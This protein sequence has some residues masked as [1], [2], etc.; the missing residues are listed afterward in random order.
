PVTIRFTPSS[1]TTFTGTL[2]VVSNDPDTPTVPVAM[3]G[4]GLVAPIAGVSPDS[5]YVAVTEGGAADRTVRLSNT[6]GSQL[7]FTVEVR[8]HLTGAVAS[9]FRGLSNTSASSSN[10]PASPA[11]PTTDGSAAVGEPLYHAATAD[12][13]ALAPSSYALTCLAADPSTG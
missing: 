4:V 11:R 9:P 6:G 7:D 12:F 8:P 10:N 2:H 1:A 5:V 3:S 13:E